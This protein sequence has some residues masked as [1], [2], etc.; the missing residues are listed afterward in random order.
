MAREILSFQYEETIPILQELADNISQKII[1]S[2][3]SA[4]KPAQQISTENRLP[5]SSTYKKIRKL[6]SLKLL[7]IDR[8]QIDD[9]GKKVLL[10]KSKIR[11]CQFYL[12][13]EGAVLQF[14][15]NEAPCIIEG[16][17]AR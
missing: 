17:M 15:G 2:T 1:L 7:C 9:S 14:E 16:I 12:R 13:Q 6:C 5:L 4:A 11:S 10:Y 3:I 8:I